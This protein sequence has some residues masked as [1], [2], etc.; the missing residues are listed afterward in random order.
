MVWAKALHWKLKIFI[1]YFQRWKAA[2]VLRCALCHRQV[3]TA[4]HKDPYSWLEVQKGQQP[5]GMVIIFL[6]RPASVGLL[7]IPGLALPASQT[8]LEICLAA[9]MLWKALISYLSRSSM[10]QDNILYLILLCSLMSQLK[11]LVLPLSMRIAESI[12]F[13]FFF[14]Q[15]SQRRPPGVLEHDQ[16]ARF[17]PPML[18]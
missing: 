2:G 5:K 10:L 3:K 1:A 11:G 17:E 9:N 4:T 13:F 8:S 15:P 12:S 6:M 18:L 14:L 7:G 16:N